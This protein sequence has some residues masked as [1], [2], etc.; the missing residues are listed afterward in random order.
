[1]KTVYFVRHGESEGN[2]GDFHQEHTTPVTEKGRQQAQIVSDRCKNLQIDVVISSALERTRQTADIIVSKIK[3]PLELSELFEEKR[4]P[5]E[6]TGTARNSSEAI[7]AGEEI[8]KNF[9][10]PGFRYSNEENFDDL[11][12]RSKNA[13]QYLEKRPEQNILVVTHGVFM[14]VLVAY[15][16][17]GD[18]LTGRE[19]EQFIRKLFMNNTGIIKLTFNEERVNAPWKLVV[20]NDHAHLG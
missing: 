16:L 11:K 9:A 12:T 3:K 7:K 13:L 14:R 6:Q 19:C 5:K 1:M 18:E 2:V 4:S 10:V 20:W 15:L 8:I 17:F